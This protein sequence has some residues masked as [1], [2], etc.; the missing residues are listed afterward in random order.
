MGEAA[1][2]VQ[3]NDQII[4]EFRQKCNEVEKLSL[5][6]DELENKNREAMKRVADLF[7]FDK[8]IFERAKEMEI[9]QLTSEIKTH[10]KELE[11]FSRINKQCFDLYLKYNEKHQEIQN[12]FH[13]HEVA[14]EAM[15]G[16]LGSVEHEKENA[17]QHNFIKLQGLF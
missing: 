12:K 13:D 15:N 14:E 1:G 2:G 8:D 4:I 16:L 3:G 17:L 5:Q 9:P 6:V 7:D 11:K 10:N